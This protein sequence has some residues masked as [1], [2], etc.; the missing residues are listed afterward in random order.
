MEQ[1]VSLAR[2]YSENGNW[3]AFSDP[4]TMHKV[5]AQQN[6]TELKIFCWVL[7]YYQNLNLKFWVDLKY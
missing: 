5:F 1:F 3:T 4:R 6:F 7:F 2:E